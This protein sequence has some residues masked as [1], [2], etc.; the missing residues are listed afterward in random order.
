ME[1]ENKLIRLLIVD[2]DF[3]KADQIISSLRA[4]GLQVRAEF[5]ED[6]ED[7]TELLDK[8]IFDLVL[9]YM[10]LP[11]FGI[12]AA[13]QLITQ[14]GKHVGLIALAKEVD[15]TVIV[16]AIK[17]GARDALS[18]DDNEH[19]I[20]VINREA[21]FIQLWRRARRLETDL[22]ESEQRCQN[23]L[24]GSKDAVAYIHE[25][26]HIFA[27]QSYMDLFRHTDFDELEGT[28]FIDMVDPAQKDELKAFLRDQGDSGNKTRLLELSLLDSGGNKL[29]GTVEFSPAS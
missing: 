17:H 4:T 18:R 8:K 27:N 29:S 5:A 24:G 19:F 28:T 2:E 26:M 13:Q 25:G 20:Q 16:D 1:T 6:G 22:Q 14:S 23:L 15:S 10:D 11:E 3:H 9:F 21:D 12:A 7:M